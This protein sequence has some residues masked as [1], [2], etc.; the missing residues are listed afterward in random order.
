MARSPQAEPSKL[1]ARV[2]LAD[3][4]PD[5]RR[6]IALLLKKAGAQV[7]VVE[8][9]QQAI[10]LALAAHHGGLLPYDVILMDMVMPEKDGF[11]ATRQL[12]EAGY[13]GPIVALTA[14]NGSGARQDCLAAG[15]DDFAAKPIERDA[16]IAVVRKWLPVERA[17]S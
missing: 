4:G 14:N 6:M 3:D 5:N 7:D 2:L 16:L 11:T 17:V 10:E 8:N 13:R 1:N 12:R 15:C 9:G